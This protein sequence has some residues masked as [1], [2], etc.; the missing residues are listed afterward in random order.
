MYNSVYPAGNEIAQI[1]YYQGVLLV[2]VAL[3]LFLYILLKV[4]HYCKWG[5]HEEQGTGESTGEAAQPEN[6]S[7]KKEGEEE[8]VSQSKV[9]GS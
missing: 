6:K 9:S 8:E 7:E 3:T 4:I 5:Y 1:H 2:E